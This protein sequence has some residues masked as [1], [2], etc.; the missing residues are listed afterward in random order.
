L[1]LGAAAGKKRRLGAIPAS[2]FASLHCVGDIHKVGR[3]WQYLFHSWLPGSGY[4]PTQGP[5][6]ELFRAHPLQHGWDKFDIDCCLPVKALPR[7]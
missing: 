5:A 2:Q 3:A 6:M 1:V 7:R 4:Q